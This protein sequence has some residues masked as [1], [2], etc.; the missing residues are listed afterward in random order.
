MQPTLSPDEHRQ[1][2]ARTGV[3]QYVSTEEAAALLGVAS[4][5]LR[6]WHCEGTG[7]IRPRKLNGRLRWSIAE[8]QAT[9]TGAASHATAA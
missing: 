7:P 8:I 3:D 1:L 4:Q 2:L 6:R 5:T 9:L